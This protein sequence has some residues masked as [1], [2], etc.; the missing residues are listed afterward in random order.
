MRFGA[1]VV[2]ALVVVA[3]VACDQTTT[4]STKTNSVT[5][6]D[7]YFAPDPDTVSVGDSV[8]FVWAGS[9]AHDVLGLND[10]LTW[11]GPRAGG[12]CNVKFLTKGSF[13]Y[14]CHFHGGMQATIVVK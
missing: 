3:S 11:C 13:P 5:V 2:V 10:G 12:F 6:G 4:G 1:S 14:F 9:A 8:L 7:N